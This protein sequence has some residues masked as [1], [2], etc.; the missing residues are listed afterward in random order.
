MTHINYVVCKH[1]W[2]ERVVFNHNFFPKMKDC[3]RLAPLKAVV[4]TVKVA[5]TRNGA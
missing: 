1:E 5:V 3:S 4:Y 2:D